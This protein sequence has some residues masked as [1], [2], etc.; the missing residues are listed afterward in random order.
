M[1]L[2]QIDAVGLDFLSRML[3]LRP[4]MRASAHDCLQHVWFRDL[5]GLRVQQQAQ[6]HQASQQQQ[7]LAQQQQQQQMQGAAAYNVPVYQ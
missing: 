4:E 2:P 5:G 3:Q 1:I 6:Q 7:L